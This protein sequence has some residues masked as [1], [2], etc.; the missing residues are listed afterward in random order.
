MS[1]QRFTEKSKFRLQGPP[2]AA[3]RLEPRR[4][5]ELSRQ[6][7]PTIPAFDGTPYLLSLVSPGFF[8][9]MLLPD[10]LSVEEVTAITL[11]QS[12][13]NGFQCFASWGP[14]KGGDPNWDQIFVRGFRAWNR[15]YPAAPLKGTKRDM[16]RL[17]SLRHYMSGISQ[18]G[19]LLGDTTKGGRDATREEAENLAGLNAQGV[20]NGLVQCP[21]CHDWRG[22]CLDPNPHFAWKVM[23]VHCRC[24]NSNFCARCGQPL[25]LRRLNANYFDPMDNQIWHVPGFLGLSHTCRDLTKHSKE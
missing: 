7:L 2:M 16:E 11:R 9:M 15:L 10:G 21:S 12:D 23:T 20:P 13:I 19:Y 14:Y 24:Q 3:A 4:V 25:Y 5:D 8:H 22:E 6:I 18:S 1:D 17:E